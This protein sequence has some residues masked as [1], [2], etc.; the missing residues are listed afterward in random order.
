MFLGRKNRR[1]YNRFFLFIVILGPLQNQNQSTHK[2]LILD[3]G[4]WMLD[5]GSWML[6]FGS[7]MFD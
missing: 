7:W 1:R 3:I 5:V 2:Y 4:C 6:Y